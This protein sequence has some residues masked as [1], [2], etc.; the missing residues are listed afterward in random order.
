MATSNIFLWLFLGGAAAFLYFLSQQWSVNRLDPKK[1]GR[2][3]RIILGGIVF[4]LGLI[5][6]VMTISISKSYQALL[7]VFLTFMFFRMLFL[8]KWQGWLNFKHFYH[9]KT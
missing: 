6:V 4:R 8:I 5:I 2:S 7:I 3:I 9:R 1:A